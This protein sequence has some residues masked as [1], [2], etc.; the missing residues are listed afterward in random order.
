[1]TQQA[2]SFSSVD[3]LDWQPHPR[4]KAVFSLKNPRFREDAAIPGLN[5]GYNT[6]EQ[7]EITKANREQ[8]FRACGADPAKTSWGLQVHGARV[9][10]VTKPG[11]YPDTDALV[12][13]VPGFALGVFVADCA[14]VLLADP[15][16]GVIATAHAGWKGAVAGIL[17]ET[18]R[19]METAG[20]R[21]EKLRAFVSPCISAARFEVGEEV[22]AQFPEAFV[23]R[24]R[25]RPYVDL[26]GFV[27]HQLLEAGLVKDAIR[28]ADGCTMGDAER[29]YSYRRDGA[30]SGRMMGLIQLLPV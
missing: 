19:V 6:P 9:Q 26:K 21:A 25:S 27:V 17:P 24:N 4:V 14:A 28:I 7:D 16:A 22:A 5:L 23:D 3:T 20:A 8:F 2:A 15:E 1:M 13:S 11:V 29:F 12:T 30:K 10:R 18:I